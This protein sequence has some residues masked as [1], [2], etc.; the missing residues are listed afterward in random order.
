M[1][2]STLSLLTLILFFLA[3]GVFAQ[4]TTTQ[5]PDGKFH[6]GAQAGYLFKNKT[7]NTNSVYHFNNGQ[8]AEINAGWRKNSIGFGLAAGYLTI[9]R[10]PAQYQYFQGSMQ[11]LYDSNRILPNANPFLVTGL[12][13]S[14]VR[15]G[16]ANHSESAGTDFKGYYVMGGPEFWFGK[17]KLQLNV[18]LKAG[19]GYSKYGYYANKGS[20]VVQKLMVADS[21]GTTYSLNYDVNYYEYSATKKQYDNMVATGS[22]NAK[23][24][25]VVHFM[26]RVG[27]NAEYF[28][29][30]KFSL[31]AGA[32]AWFIAKQEMVTANGMSGGGFIQE[33]GGTYAEQLRPVY[34]NSIKD[35]NQLIFLSANVGVK[36]WMGKNKVSANKKPVMPAPA[37]PVVTET[38]AVATAKDLAISVKDEATGLAL[39]G[40]KVAVLL[41]GTPFT[42]ATT[43]ENGEIEKIIAVAPGEYSIVGEKNSIKTNAIIVSNADFASAARTISKELLHNDSRFTLIGYTIDKKTSDKKAAVKTDLTNNVTNNKLSQNSD[44][45][46]KFIYQLDQGTDYSVVATSLGV[47]SN[48]EHVTTKGL[49][50]SKT[51]YVDLLLGVDELSSGNK[52]E[53]KNILYDL[54][55]YDIRA[56]AEKILDNLVSTMNN[57]PSIRIE[58]SSHTDSRASASY[59]MKLSQKRAEA[60]VNYLVSHGISRNRLVAKGYGETQ[61]LN[62]CADGVDCTEAEHQANRRTEVRVL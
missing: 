39:S 52:F 2:K 20:G 47:F 18:D 26:G 10:D 33:I 60:A 28:V 9:K 13:D 23:E 49:D 14:Q 24:K 55:K 25:S 58:L 27:A 35:D 36:Y 12:D 1:K 42:T 44:V 48:I 32:A 53:V 3:T 46:G 22:I 38:K 29:T 30:P 5:Y 17:K 37:L 16:P 34:N 40:V 54:A 6:L 11:Q 56:D 57:N 62:S 21:A 50:R 41:N 61:L 7:L 45:T 43:N 15:F 8:F 31:H 59:N 19:I 4:T 51:L